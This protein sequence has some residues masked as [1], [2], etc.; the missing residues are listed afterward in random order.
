MKNFVQPGMDLT[1]AAPSGGVTSGDFVLIG[2]LFGVAASTADAGDDVVISTVGVY[3]LPKLG[4]QA[5]TVGAPIYWDATES[6]MTT[7]STDNT[8][9]GVAV[10]VAANP[11]DTGLV[12]LD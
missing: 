5:W 12:K 1:V 4:A 2:S 11:S 10:A 7:V 8:L 3:E 6:H 9:V